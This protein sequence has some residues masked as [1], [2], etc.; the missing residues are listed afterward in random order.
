LF[1][2]SSLIEPSFWLLLL[3][4]SRPASFH[5][6]DLRRSIPRIFLRSEFIEDEVRRGPH[7]RWSWLRISHALDRGDD[8]PNGRGRRHGD[9]LTCRRRPA[10]ACSEPALRDL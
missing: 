10:G 6:D 3:E 1:I 9:R 5:T 4:R 2:K 7:A 8:P